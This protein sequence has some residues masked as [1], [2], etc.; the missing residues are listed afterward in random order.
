MSEAFFLVR[1]ENT[2][3]NGKI[4]KCMELDILNGK[5][6]FLKENLKKTKKKDLEFI[7]LERKYIWEFGKIM[8]YGEM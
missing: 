6:H 4:I 5:K 3:D 8:C 7:I 1:I 2:K